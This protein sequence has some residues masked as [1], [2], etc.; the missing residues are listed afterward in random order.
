MISA[1]KGK[2]WAVLPGETHVDTGSGLVLKVL[3]PVSSYSR[4]K[5]MDEVVLHTVLR[6]KDE[7]FFLYGFLSLKEKQLFQRM[8]AVSGIG[9]KTALSMI[10]AFSIDE[11]VRAVDGGDVARLSS[12]PGIGKKTAQRIILELT[13]KLEFAEEKP[14]AEDVRLREDLISGLVN[15]GYPVRGVRDQ[16]NKLLKENPDERSFEV[17]FKALLKK[18]SKL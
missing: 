9:G 15:L 17:L 13:G 2:L 8:I 6:Q 1:I 16:V 7:E 12:V 4:I 10:S 3:T 5:Q 14:E 11:F 18:I